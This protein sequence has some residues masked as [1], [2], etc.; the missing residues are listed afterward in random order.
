M[1]QPVIFGIVGGYGATGKIVAA[2]L[3]KSTKAEIIIG[4][5]D[6]VKAQ[7][8]AAEYDNRV[9]AV[10]LDAL[11]DNSLDEFCGRCSIVINCR[12]PVKKLRD[13]VAQAA[14]RKRC[15]YI[16]P[17]GMSVIKEGISD[18]DREITD[19][20]LSFVVSAGWMPGLT[21]LLPVYAQAKAKVIMEK[22]DSVTVYFGDCGD[23]SKNA[24]RD[25]VWYLRQLGL[26]S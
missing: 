9:S 26:R 15:H 13:R 20:K 21:E 12:G 8:V 14:L 10:G 6:P 4:G 24:L 11:D 2:N 25:G 22:L 17:A 7:A 18:R 1:R 16:D 3:H 5:R 19:L 23:W